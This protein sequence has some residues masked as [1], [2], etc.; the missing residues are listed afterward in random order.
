[1][2]FNLL[3]KKN[4]TILDWRSL[5]QVKETGV[6]VSG[7]ET[8]AKD[9][10]KVF[11]QYWDAA[12]ATSLPIWD[13]NVVG[14][15]FTASNPMV[16]GGDNTRTY[17]AS[18]PATFAAYGRVDELDA[19]MLAINSSKSFLKFAVMDYI[20]TSM[21]VSPAFYWPNID[22]AL[23]SAALSG[24]KISLM[25]SIWNSTNPKELPY[26]RSLASIPNIEVKT[27]KVPPS[28]YNPQA[29][30]SRVSHSKFIV[31]DQSAYVTTSNC[32][33]DYY[34][35]TGGVSV[36]ILG[37]SS[38]TYATLI[39]HFDQDFSSPFAGPIPTSLPPKGR[40]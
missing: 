36:T 28:P 9:L 17:I 15:T 11:T 39:E 37:T 16:I 14:T 18:G 13:P 12:A 1:M 22:D 30:F 33:A 21:Y 27:Y 24:V 3:L 4:L 29:P 19:I 32:G 25:F 35:Y 34:L 23:R 40:P 10:G 7:C 2:K 5:S 31:T 8:F 26:W 38:P 6:F 20:P